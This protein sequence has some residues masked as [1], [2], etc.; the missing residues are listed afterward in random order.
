MTFFPE[1]HLHPI[2]QDLN[3]GELTNWLYKAN[4]MSWLYLPQVKV[5]HF[6]VTFVHLSQIR[7][8]LLEKK[9]F[10]FTLLYLSIVVVSVA[11]S[12]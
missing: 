4:A 1:R 5:V 12:C 8:I 2:A 9:P 3:D 6:K 11:T 10:L 7:H